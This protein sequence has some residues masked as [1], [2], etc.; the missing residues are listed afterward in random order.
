MIKRGE[1][2]EKNVKAKRKRELIGCSY[3]TTT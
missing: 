3:I 2:E 1:E